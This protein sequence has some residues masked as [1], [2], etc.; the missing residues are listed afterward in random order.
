MGKSLLLD[1]KGDLAEE[2]LTLKINRSYAARLEV[3]DATCVC[4]LNLLHFFS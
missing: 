3:R 1:D 4:N 2:D